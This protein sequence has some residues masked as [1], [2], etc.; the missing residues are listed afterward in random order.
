LK[1]KE[2]KVEKVEKKKDIIQDLERI[3]E[4]VNEYTMLVPVPR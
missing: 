3:K 4:R 2:K 1:K